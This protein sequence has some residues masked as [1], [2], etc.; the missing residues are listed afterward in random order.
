MFFNYLLVVQQSKA[1][2]IQLFNRL[3]KNLLLH[4][5][6]LRLNLM[7]GPMNLAFWRRTKN[8]ES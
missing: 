8:P 7:N 1:F 5:S 3:S 2:R 6:I 4:S